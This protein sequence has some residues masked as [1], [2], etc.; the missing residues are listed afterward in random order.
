MTATGEVYLRRRGSTG[1]HY[2]AYSRPGA[3]EGSAAVAG[4]YD[5][6]AQVADWRQL[7][8][9]QMRGSEPMPD[10]R[11]REFRRLDPHHRMGRSPRN[12]FV[13]HDYYLQLPPVLDQRFRDLAYAI[14]GDARTPLE[15]ARRI[16]QHLRRNYRYTLDLPPVSRENPIESFLFETR[17]GHCEYFATAMTLLARAVGLPARHVNG[18]VG[19]DYNDFGDFYAVRQSHAHSWVEVWLP[20]DG[21]AGRWV[22]FDPTPASGL[23]PDRSGGLWA[24]LL[25]LVDSLRMFWYRHVID[26]DLEAQLRAAEA[27]LGLERDGRSPIFQGYRA[28]RS[29]LRNALVLLVQFFLWLGAGFFYARRHARERPWSRLDAA[30]GLGWLLSAEALVLLFWRPEPGLGA[31]VLAAFPPVVT[32]LLAWRLRLRPDEAGPRRRRGHLR[33]ESR[34]FLRLV[35]A[36]ER[37]GYAYGPSDT[38]QALLAQAGARSASY[39]SALAEAVALYERCRF[40]REAVDGGVRALRRQ[41]RRLVRSVRREGRAKARVA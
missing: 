12:P 5:P 16:A 4:Y 25:A 20:T 2:L 38:P 39:R 30:V 33:P 23:P 19:G 15:R 18:Y 35:R 1:V 36:L 14:V 41:V 37:A 29:A 34:L 26:Y 32:V 31:A 10:F 6:A 9:G 21:A 3:S 17:R 28:T 8:W 13:L 11:R 40:G 7:L 24:S 22:T 27:V